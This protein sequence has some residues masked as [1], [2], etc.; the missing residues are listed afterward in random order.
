M[1]IFNNIVNLVLEA[2]IPGTPDWFNEVL[3]KHESLS[4]KSP[5]TTESDLE[6]NFFPLLDEPNIPEQSLLNIYANRRILDFLQTLYDSMTSQPKDWNTFKTNLSQLDK[7]G[8]AYNIQ[9]KSYKDIS[10]WGI[11][12]DKIQ[13]SLQATEKLADSKSEVALATYADES[14]LGA[15]QAMI[16]KRVDFFT[17]V[18]KLKS[19][20]TPFTNLIKDVFSY[21]EAYLSGAKKYTSDFE[22]IDN[23]YISNLIDIALAAKNFFISELTKL[24]LSQIQNAGLNLTDLIMGQILNEQPSFRGGA[25]TTASGIVVPAGFTPA[26]T[27]TTPTTS[28]NKIDRNIIQKVRTEIAP[29]IISRLDFLAGKP[30]KYNLIDPST[31]EE[32]TPVVTKTINPNQY[33]IGEILNLSKQP[34]NK[35]PEAVK[36]INALKAVSQHIKKKPGAGERMSQLGQGL[37]ALA[38]AAGVKLYG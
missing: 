31:G 8:S 26:P 27:R 19:P 16:N 28:N 35:N 14:I 34:G 11:T 13:K 18:A 3:T 29:N 24:K 36:L 12:N 10:E 17:R 9:T 22:G 30:V 38:S 4:P 37:G 6:K 20:T 33:S 15:V 5:K 1:V 25:T 2:V 23:F 32:K 7:M 21:P